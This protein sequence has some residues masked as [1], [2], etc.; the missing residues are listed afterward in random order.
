MFAITFELKIT[1]LQKHYDNDKISQAY[2][3]IKK[4]LENKDF[5]F[6]YSNFYVTETGNLATVLDALLELKKLKWFSSSLKDLKS[7]EIKHWS[8]CSEIVKG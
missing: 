5:K 6:I 2:Y 4:S 3:D 1:E 7:F 8:D